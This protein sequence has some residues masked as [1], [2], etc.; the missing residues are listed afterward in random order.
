MAAK[1]V[2]TCSSFLRASP[3]VPLVLLLFN[4]LPDVVRIDMSP[5]AAG[6]LALTLN[7]S[8]FNCRVWRA[9]LAEVPKE[10][11]EAALSVGMRSGLR[12]RR[13]CYLR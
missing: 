10:K 1:L 11:I 12:L 7:T 8:T 4:G 9:A 13:I 3:L 2:A 5:I 6:V